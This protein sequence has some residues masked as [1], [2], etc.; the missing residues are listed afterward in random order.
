MKKL[1][2]GFVLSLSSYAS[3]KEVAEFLAKHTKPSQQTNQSGISPYAR[4]YPLLNPDGKIVCNVSLGKPFPQEAVDETGKLKPG[5][6]WL[7][8]LAE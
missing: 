5:W 3:E 6:R 7:F 1:T 2:M 8:P 4:A